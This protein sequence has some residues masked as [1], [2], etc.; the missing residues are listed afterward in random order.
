[1]CDRPAPETGVPQNEVTPET[2]AIGAPI[3]E[4]WLAGNRDVICEMGGT[5]DY[6][7][8]LASLWASWKKS[9]YS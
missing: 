2:I 5:G 8:L 3:F 9:L 6:Q 4:D 7:A 1:M